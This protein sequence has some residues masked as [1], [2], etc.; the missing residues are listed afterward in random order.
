MSWLVK[1]FEDPILKVSSLYDELKKSIL[2]ESE[3]E[4]NRRLNICKSCDRLNHL[5]FCSE[6][7]CYMPAKCALNI[8]SCILGKHNIEIKQ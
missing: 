6:C 2:V 1:I 8:N 5:N 3:E 7:N 4:Y